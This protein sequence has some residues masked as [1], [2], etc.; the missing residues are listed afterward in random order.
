V[1]S[2]VIVGGLLPSGHVCRRRAAFA[3]ALAVLIRDG[4]RA[5]DNPLSYVRARPPA[6][7]C[8]T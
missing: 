1:A 3:I 8:C 4:L 7:R 5:L 6:A 2:H